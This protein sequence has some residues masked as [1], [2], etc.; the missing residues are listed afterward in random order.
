MRTRQGRLHGWIEEY[1][2]F[3]YSASKKLTETKVP[4]NAS[5]IRITNT[6]GAVT[7]DLL[8]SP[9]DIGKVVSIRNGGSHA[10]TIKK[11]G[12]S[13]SVTN[14]TKALVVID[15]FGFTVIGT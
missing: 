14:G 2:V 7:L 1:G 6:S 10:A 13:L 12:N 4:P 3:E 5:V 15:G 8:P 11:G 9:D